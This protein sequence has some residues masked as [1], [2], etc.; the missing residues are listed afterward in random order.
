M[1]ASLPELRTLAAGGLIFIAGLST[2]CTSGD[3]HSRVIDFET[4][5]GTKLAFDVSPDGSTIVL[6]LL[7]QLW[8]M[9][10][11][12]GQA[13]PLTD[14]V[15]DGSDDLGPTF[16]PDGETVAFSADRPGGAGLFRVSLGDRSVERLT[17]GPHRS[18]AWSPDGERIA[19]IQG[20]SIHLLDPDG[21]DPSEVPIDSLP[22]RG[23][24]D[25]SWSPRDGRLVF[26]NAPPGSRYGGP[27]W[28]VSPDGGV[29]QPLSTGDLRARAP[30]FSPDG[31]RI[32]FFSPDSA[33]Q[34][35]VWVR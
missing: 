1:P 9:P 18:T 28:A 11:E 24:S 10:A 31:T 21:G 7:G 30:I 33:S 12:G 27:I 13:T 22:Q 26:V 20:Q 29:P 17:T 8:T 19:F 25:P 6:D 16:S 4:S 15:R 32:A 2:S 35:Q 3:S 34:F 23:T 14:A 5:E